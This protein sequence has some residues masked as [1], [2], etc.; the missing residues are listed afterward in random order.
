M[1]CEYC[2]ADKNGYIEPLE[3]NAHIFLNVKPLCECI[4]VKYKGEKLRSISII[5]CPMCGRNFMREDRE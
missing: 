4:E 1:S 3:K 5:Y 2:R